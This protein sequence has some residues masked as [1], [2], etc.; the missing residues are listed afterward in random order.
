MTTL[1]MKYNNYQ[2]CAAA[3]Y[4]ERNDMVSVAVFRVMLSNT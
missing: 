3:V 4:E 2:S 1:P